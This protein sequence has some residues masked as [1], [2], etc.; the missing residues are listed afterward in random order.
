MGKKIGHTTLMHFEK[1][2]ISFSVKLCLI[3]TH[4]KKSNC[5]DQVQD[6][7]QFEK[8]NKFKVC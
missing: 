2:N 3:S 4:L 1:K 6:L 5:V 8:K 7:A